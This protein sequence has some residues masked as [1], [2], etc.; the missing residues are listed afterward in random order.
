MEWILENLIDDVTLDELIVDIWLRGKLIDKSNQIS[1]DDWMRDEWDDWGSDEYH[2]KHPV[3]Q[4]E[5]F[6]MLQY[7]ADNITQEMFER[8]FAVTEYEGERLRLATMYLD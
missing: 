6:Q 7:I 3:N 2:W 4:T 5:F 8:S 1:F